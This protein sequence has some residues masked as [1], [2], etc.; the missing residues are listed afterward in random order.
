MDRAG[1]LIIVGGFNVH[2][3]EVEAVLSSYPGVK[4]AVVVGK[5]NS[6]SGQIPCGYVILDPGA[7]VTSTELISYCKGHLAHYKVPR[8]IE[9]VEDFPRNSLGKVLRR[10]LRDSLNRV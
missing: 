2:P 7:S 4:E 3:Q 9:T 6:F 5:E 8:K 10:V 1:D